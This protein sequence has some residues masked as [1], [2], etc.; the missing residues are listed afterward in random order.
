MPAEQGVPSGH[1]QV[2][3][4]RLGHRD[5]RSGGRRDGSRLA[6]E[7]SDNMVVG[8]L[9]GLGHQLCQ[10]GD[11]RFSADGS[12]SHEVHELLRR[13]AREVWRSEWRTRRRPAT[14]R[15]GNS[16]DRC[17]GQCRRGEP[18]DDR[19]D[20]SVGV[21]RTQGTRRLQRGLGLFGGRVSRDRPEPNQRSQDASIHHSL[22][23]EGQNGAGSC[24]RERSGNSLWG[25]AAGGLGVDQLGQHLVERRNAVDHADRQG[26]LGG[27][28]AALAELLGDRLGRGPPPAGDRCQKLLVG[29][30]DAGFDRRPGCLGQ[31]FDPVGVGLGGD[32]AEH[33]GRDPR[34]GVGLAGLLVDRHHPDRA[35]LGGGAGDHLARLA[36]DPVG[37]GSHLQVGHRQDRFALGGSRDAGRQLGGAGDG[38]PGAVDVQHDRLHLRVGGGCVDRGPH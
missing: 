27:Q 32:R 11:P 20:R 21:Q 17:R 12:Q 38:P 24:A 29:L 31:G 8:Q 3:G 5:A 1:P 33:C 4:F 34:L 2:I 36:R 16:R 22:Q 25:C 10:Q 26:L 13:D 15:A 18:R 6:V 19:L 35:D 9:A 14:V 28:R 7:P 23:T 37:G 30:G